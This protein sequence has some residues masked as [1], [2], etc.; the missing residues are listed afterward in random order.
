[1][2]YGFVASSGTATQVVQM[3]SEME[4]AGWDGYFT[5]DAISIGAMDTWDPWTILGAA[6]VTTSRVTLGAMIFPLARRR[7]WKV[8]REV[9]T[10]DHLSGGRLVLPVGL[11]VPD[12]A[13]VSRVSGEAA[14]VR[15]RAERLDDALAILERA[16][17]GRPF[18][19]SGEHLSVTGLHIAPPTVQ[20]PRVPVWVVGAWPSERSMA[21]AARWDG[22]VLQ[23]ARSMTPLTPADVTEAAQWL[24]RRRARLRDEGVTIPD[25]YDVV[26]S[27]R[28]PDDPA[29]AADHVA[30]FGEAGATWWIEGRWDPQVDTHEALVARVR[31][32]P[33]VR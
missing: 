22:V 1:M 12:D 21:R 27:D 17:T 29:L 23:R 3:A 30:A 9:L 20:Q 24:E 5:W 32:G 6:A 14:T 11:G 4:A 26:V 2:R 16:A 25:A 33:P 19:W 7:P 8:A 15:E 28:S 31:Q 10:V 13:G 18:T